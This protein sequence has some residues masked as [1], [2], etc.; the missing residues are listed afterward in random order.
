[1]RCI[2]DTLQAVEDDIFKLDN[3]FD[4][5]I[6]DTYVEI[7]HPAGFIF[8]S[9]LE[10]QILTGV[11]STVLQLSQAL[12]FINFDVVGDYVVRKKA[13]RAAKLL[14]SIKSRSDIHLTNQDRLIQKC[15][16]QNISITTDESGRLVTSE[17]D[18]VGLLEILDRRLYDYDLVEGQVEIYV[19]GS[20]KIRS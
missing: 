16:T 17:A 8:V 3:D 7:L 13:R 14:A 4:F 9:D 6:H 5:I 1:M 10:A 12:P 18:I 15:C 19:A 2:D 20:R 11:S